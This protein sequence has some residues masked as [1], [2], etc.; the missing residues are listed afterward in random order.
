[1]VGRLV[2][3]REVRKELRRWRMKG[4]KGEGYKK[5]KQKFRELNNRGKN[6]R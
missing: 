3:K 4:G 1:M 5:M 6:N 2:K